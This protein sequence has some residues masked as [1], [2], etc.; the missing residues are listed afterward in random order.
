[1]GPNPKKDQI[2]DKNAAPLEAETE[3]AEESNAV[4]EGLD[5]IID[6]DSEEAA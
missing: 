3:Q 6:K 4:E 2:I 1:M 5:Q